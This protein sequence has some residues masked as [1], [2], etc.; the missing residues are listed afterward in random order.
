MSP[1]FTFLLLAKTVMGVV[2]F[3]VIY[4][5]KLFMKVCIMPILTLR[6]FH[7]DSSVAI[8]LLQIQIFLPFGVYHFSLA[9]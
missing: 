8:A 6:T 7:V 9:S 2:G 4:I 3:F 5:L 1:Q